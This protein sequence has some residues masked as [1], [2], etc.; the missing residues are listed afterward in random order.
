MKI[1]IREVKLEIYTPSDCLVSIR[2]AL[3]EIG[4]CHI[5]NY[6]QVMAYQISFGSWR[7]LPGSKPYEGKINVINNGKEIKMEVICP[8]NKVEEAIKAIKKVHVYE[9]PV[10]YIIPLINDLFKVN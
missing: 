3:N 5:G 7:P 10:I 6:D 4:A 8:L 2:D 1:D 9:E